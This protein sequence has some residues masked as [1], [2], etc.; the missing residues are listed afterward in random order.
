MFF[1]VHTG[2]TNS[3]YLVIFLKLVQYSLNMYFCW[4]FV[5]FRG[6]NSISKTFLCCRLSLICSFDYPRPSFSALIR[7]LIYL[8]SVLSTD[9]STG[10]AGRYEHPD[11]AELFQV[12][13]DP[14][15]LS[16]QSHRSLLCCKF[17][18]FMK[19]FF[20]KKINFFDQFLS[21]NVIY[22]NGFNIFNHSNVF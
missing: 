16:L 15:S 22:L 10:N 17:N 5:T 13:D 20:R 18:D 14:T 2:I 1:L 6:D 12:T 9:N 3:T 11:A 4:C 7:Q 21:I 19:E 8:V